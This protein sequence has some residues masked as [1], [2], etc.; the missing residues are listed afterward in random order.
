MVEIT[1]IKN[2]ND[3]VEVI[4]E[5][6]TTENTGAQS[7]LE[8]NIE[9]IENI[10]DISI[11][12]GCKTTIVEHVCTPEVQI[13][14][15]TIVT[16]DDILIN[17]NITNLRELPI[18]LENSNLSVDNNTVSR[19]DITD[20]K[21][22][23][24]ADKQENFI[25]PSESV[26]VAGYSE[27]VVVAALKWKQEELE[28]CNPKKRTS[29]NKLLDN[30]SFRFDIYKENQVA[31]ITERPQIWLQALYAYSCSE[32]LISRWET[33][34]NKTKSKIYECTLRLCFNSVQNTIITIKLSTGVLFVKG[35]SNKS[36]IEKEF[37]VVKN[38]VN[39]IDPLGGF[40]K[41]TNIEKK[42][43][44][45]VT[46]N[47]TNDIEIEEENEIEILWNENAKLKNAIK[48]LENDICD[49]NKKHEEQMKVL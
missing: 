36:W 21:T 14:E 42:E 18:L 16:P 25:S 23:L 39:V 26:I 5:E 37:D 2:S 4:Q 6:S 3:V 24:L 9:S 10:N 12:N 41:E 1:H 15:N 49:I 17:N 43:D 11:N 19:D 38:L 13:F 8:F 47:Y 27:P 33:K 7:I 30:E 45:I 31:F 44:S 29:V 32:N 35:I 22:E 46:D 40:T 34:I 20:N 48:I 28:T